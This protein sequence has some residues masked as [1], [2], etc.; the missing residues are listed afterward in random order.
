VSA[1]S[2]LSLASL[3]AL[4]VGLA[5]LD[6]MGADSSAA[7]LNVTGVWQ[8]DYVCTSA[9]C[10]GSS[11]PD[12]LTLKQAPG[13]TSVTGSDQINGTIAGTLNGTSLKFTETDGSYTANF[14]V[15]VSANGTSWSG[16]LT[17]SNGTSGTD[18][19]T[20]EGAPVL[21]QSGTVAPVSGTVLVEAPGS[22]TF[23][24]LSS[25]STIPFGS[26]IDATNGTVAITVA[27]P[28]GGTAG[29]DFYDGEFTLTQARS[30]G[31]TEKLAG[32]SFAACT[33]GGAT[34][35]SGTTGTSGTSGATRLA[36]ARASASSKGTVVRELWGHAHGKF[37]TS[38][39]GGAATVLGTVWLTEDQC[40]GTLFKAVKDSITVVDFAHP[41]QKHRI[42]Q[43]HS[44]LALLKGS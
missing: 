37:T 3:L 32:G 31:T 9:S 21:A 29:G 39:R 20:L 40:D 33:T 43:G 41:G 23:E 34:G 19:A 16:T 4:V 26:T 36:G 22:Q 13:S 12:T 25:S 7:A 2:R 5:G 24:P 11:F 1:R 18:T 10:A 6:A 17:D 14:T 38:G 42:A 35:A 8:S 44:Y 15:T 30:G 27:E 28:G